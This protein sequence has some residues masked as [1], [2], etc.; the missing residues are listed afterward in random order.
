MYTLGFIYQNGH[1]H[2]SLLFK[3]IQRKDT[4][5]KQERKKDYIHDNENRKRKLTEKNF[6]E[7]LNSKQTGLN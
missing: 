7:F 5:K 1:T 2:L 3:I 4:K 6:E